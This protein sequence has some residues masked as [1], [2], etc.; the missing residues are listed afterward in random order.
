[1]S[2]RLKC[3]LVGT[4]HDKNDNDVLNVKTIPLSS[5]M[6]FT[7]QSARNIFDLL[8]IFPLDAER[9][10]TFVFYIVVHE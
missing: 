9:L 6:Y 2:K 8:T 5:T 1:M 10:V 3:L 4:R 7:I